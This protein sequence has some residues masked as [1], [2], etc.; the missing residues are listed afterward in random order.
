MDPMLCMAVTVQRMST[1]DLT[2]ACQRQVQQCHHTTAES[3]QRTALSESQ[4]KLSSP[5]AGQVRAP[6]G[7]S[8]A[9]GQCMQA[10][11][12]GQQGR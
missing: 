12:C 9:A 1:A 4:P 6:D 3:R 8:H 2:D 10:W 11:P 7:G 5:S